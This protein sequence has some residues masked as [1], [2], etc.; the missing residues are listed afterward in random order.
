MLHLLTDPKHS[1]NSV[2]FSADGDLLVSGSDDKTL[3]VWSKGSSGTFECQSTF[4][5]HT[6]S[7]THATQV[8]FIDADTVVSSSDDGTTCVWD[9][10]TGT[11]TTDF[12]GDTFVVTES[13]DNEQTV[14]QYA[15]TKNND[16]IL[17][18]LTH[19]VAG[20]EAAENNNENHYEN[21]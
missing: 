17:V 3:K 6:Q 14:G 19:A 1:V 12:E 16:L 11:Q 15:V 4:T 2:C 7:D 5:R 8:E 13:S 10:S 9:M 21:H 20:T 18:H